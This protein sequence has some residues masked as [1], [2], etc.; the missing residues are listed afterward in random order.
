MNHFV[1]GIHLGLL[2]YDRDG[3]LGN[4]YVFPCYDKAEN[5]LYQVSAIVSA[6][7][8][9]EALKEMNILEWHI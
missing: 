4:C 1:D 9:R 7:V 5:V 8:V 2:R 6:N 3:K